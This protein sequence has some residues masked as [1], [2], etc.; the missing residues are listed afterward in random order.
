MAVTIRKPSAPPPSAARVRQAVAAIYQRRREAG[1]DD[2]H[3]WSD[4]PDDVISYVAAHRRVPEEVLVADARDALLLVRFV[5]A[6]L[7]ARELAFLD[8]CRAPA[9]GI[10]VT[11]EEL[12][13]DLGAH[14]PQAAQQRWARHTQAAARATRPPFEEERER[15]WTLEHGARVQQ[16]AAALLRAHNDIAVC[17][18]D[19]QAVEWLEDLE[20][21]LDHD[22]SGTHEQYAALL[23]YFALIVKAMGNRWER[24][25]A[26]RSAKE[27]VEEYQ[28]VQE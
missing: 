2:L 5:R 11:W 6:R 22:F 24:V 15:A 19:R 18:P 7:D 28:A 8:T 4:S 23:V 10:R 17:A 12:A 3:L 20:V 16:V 13:S 21:A 27:L 1:D 26:V 25:P 14:S 9:P